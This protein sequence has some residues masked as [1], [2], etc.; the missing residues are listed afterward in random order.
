MIQIID[1]H[2]CCGCEGCVQICPK[3]CI[4]F[5]EDEKGFRYPLVDKDICIN[6]GLCD[7]VCPFLNL[8]NTR[9][10]IKVIAAINPDEE[11]RMK[12]SSGGI[13]TILAEHTI[14]AGGVVFGACFD[15]KWE[16]KHD[17][18]D[19][20]DGIST[21][22]GA[23]YVQSKICRAFIKV[24]TFL[25]KDRKVLFSGTGC[26][27]AGLRKFLRKEYDNLLTVEIACH[28]VPSPAVWRAYINKVAKGN[29][30][31]IRNINFRDKRNGWNGY[32]LAITTNEE[33]IYERASE[34]QYMQSFLRD[35]CL[36]PSCSNCPSKKGASGAAL[37][38]GDFWGVESIR[39]EIYDNKGCSLV[40][41]NS[42]YGE[43]IINELNINH[44]KITYEDGY[45]YN[46]CFI[47]PLSENR[48]APIFWSKFKKRD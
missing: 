27:I 25:D 20:V 44:S 38:I 30:S 21:F 8:T 7:K 19:T 42:A 29:L 33:T 32:G 48:Y 15:D 11:L 47:S 10:P 34:N 36:R 37:I 26:Q 2:F 39:P 17:F 41:I 14:K 1:K 28:G 43:Q 4:S 13:F 45:R 6:C 18:V 35:L 5:N 46:P 16:V 40:V 24:K 3:Q 23:K 12:S 9:N 31:K 22:R